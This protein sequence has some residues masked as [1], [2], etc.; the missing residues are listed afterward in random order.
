MALSA[1]VFPIP[2][3]VT[4]IP[5]PTLALENAPVAEPVEIVTRSPD[6]TPTNAAVPVFSVAV[7][8]PS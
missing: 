7:V 8:R 5:V 6:T 3:T 4:V 1:P 2:A